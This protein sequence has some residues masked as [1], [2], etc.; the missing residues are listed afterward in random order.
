MTRVSKPPEERKSE[1]LDT[2]EALFVSRGYAQTTVN[3]II[4]TMGVAKGTFYYYFKSK[5][6]VMHAIVARVAE[7]VADMAARI[8]ADP[9]LN[10]AEKIFRVITA[11]PRDDKAE[12]LEELHHI[13][14]AQMHLAS[15][16]QCLTLLAP[17]MSKI[18]RQGMDEGIFRSEYPEETMEFL[19][20]ASQFIFDEGIFQ[21]PK[22]E[23]AKKA[24]AF[25]HITERLLG[26]EEGSF[27]YLFDRLAG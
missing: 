6:E 9:S 3:D 16:K 18:V 7:S 5:E 1:I 26:E 2:A 20:A 4:Q 8:A 27:S 17:I 25:V 11:R 14:N 12:L 21:W 13:D 24:K 15:L 23:L 22:E 19:L 10:A